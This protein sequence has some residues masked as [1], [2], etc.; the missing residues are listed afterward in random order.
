VPKRDDDDDE[1]FQEAM[2]GARPLP[3]GHGRVPA[4]TPARERAPT[5]AKRA[6]APFIVEQSGDAMAG[7]AT[8]LS[9]KELR[10]LRG[11]ERDIDARVDLHGRDRASAVRELER[12]VGEAR[13]RG[14][15]VVLVIHGRGRGSDTGEPV[16][17]P[18]VWDWLAGPG[19]ERCG[20]MGFATAPPRHGGNGA[21]LVMLRRD[22]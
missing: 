20:V 16:L 2:R 18:A 19:A 15:R 12:F 11:G 3:A 22:R 5:R 21:T 6:A 1:A 7:R 9:A 10:A 17:R 14:A 4:V 13:A 8:D